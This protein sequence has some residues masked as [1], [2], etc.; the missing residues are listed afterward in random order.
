MKQAIYYLNRSLQPATRFYFA[1]L[2][3][4]IIICASAC[5]RTELPP[6]T[7]KASDY[8]ADVI[9][10]WLTLQIRLFTNAK[11][12]PNGAFARPFAYAGITAFEST[13]PGTGSWKTK[14]NGLSGLPVTEKFKPYYWPASVNA[15]LATFNRDFFTVSNSSS[16]DLAAIDSLEN[17]LYASFG[18][19]QLQ[20]LQRSAAF[21]KSIADVVF[22]W[23]KTD[24][25][26]ENNVLAY[27]P[28]VG[29]GLWIPTPPAFAVASGPY[30]GSNRPVISGSDN[31]AQPGAPLAYSEDLKS[32]FYAMV[33]D[34]YKASKVLTDD[35][36]AWALFWRDV[37]G[38]TTPG[39]WLSIIRQVIKQTNSHLDKAAQTYALVGI[40]LYDANTSVMKT[41]YTYNLIRPVSY[42]RKVMGDASWLSLYLHRRILNTVLPMLL[43]LPQRPQH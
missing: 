39:H 18:S 15:A 13:D 29:T 42:I 43:C 20:V 25:Y 17:A 11:G 38:V 12:I 4:S 35:Q 33:N 5:K 3:T 6:T 31:H 37:P 27:T 32:P 30:W 28:P 7:K 8:P 24:G 9:D 14:Y 36:K 19:A 1:C 34:L 23:S 21:G 41:K 40:C 16:T 26:A 10:K 22:A 2:I